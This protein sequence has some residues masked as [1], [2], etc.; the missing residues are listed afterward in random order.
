MISVSWFL[1]IILNFG[2]FGSIILFNPL[3]LNL[4]NSLEADEGFDLNIL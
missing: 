3:E 2:N 1:S 4:E